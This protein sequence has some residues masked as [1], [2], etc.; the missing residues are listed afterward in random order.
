M[1][2]VDE[3]SIP[4]GGGRGG[5]NKRQEL[6]RPWVATVARVLFVPFLLFVSLL[7]GLMIGYSVLGDRPVSEVFH[8]ETYKHMFD[9]IF[10]GTER[11]S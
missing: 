11:Q 5:K 9:L 3:R 6:E 4:Q 1:Q 7:A 8:P 10:S 2:K